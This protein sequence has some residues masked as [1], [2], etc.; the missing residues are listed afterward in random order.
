M[1]TVI[2]YPSGAARAT[3][4]VPMLPVAPP[5]FSMMM[6]WPSAVRMP[7]AIRRPTTSVSPPGGN[8]TI[9]VIGRDGYACARA[10]RG[11]AGSAAAPA[12]RCRKFRRGSFIFEPPFTSFDH[13]VGAGEQRRRHF[14][15]ERSCGPQVDDQLV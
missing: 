1:P 15:A 14:E 5:T 9:I 3:R 4:P 2:V 12:A 13:L 10:A 7:S 8:G 6:V 11:T